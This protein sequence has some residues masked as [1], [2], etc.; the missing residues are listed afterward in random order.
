MLVSI[1]FVVLFRNTLVPCQ[2]S[3]NS[4]IYQASPLI[5]IMFCDVALLIPVAIAIEY[6]KV[7]HDQ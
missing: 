4:L 3:I 2:A 1:L 5:T 6:H 7:D